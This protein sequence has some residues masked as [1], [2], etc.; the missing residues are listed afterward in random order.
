MLV[1]KNTLGAIFQNLNALFNK[2]FAEASVVWQD[3]AMKVPSTTSVV[4]CA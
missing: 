2:A 3:V 4:I 1:N